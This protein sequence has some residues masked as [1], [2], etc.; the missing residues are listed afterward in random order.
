M[1]KNVEIDEAN[2]VEEVSKVRTIGSKEVGESPEDKAQR[3]EELKEQKIAEA[4]AKAKEIAEKMVKKQ[5][6]TMFLQVYDEI[7]NKG[8]TLEDVIEE[9][10]QKNSNMTRS[11]RDFV[12]NFEPDRIK[13]WIEDEN[14]D[15]EKALQEHLKRKG[16][17][18]EEE[19]K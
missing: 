12:L 18:A 2:V 11:A 1:K 3:E 14:N 5:F 15:R 6:R 16:L 8:K 9:V 13:Q 4:Q 7:Q 17:V 19:S 10:N